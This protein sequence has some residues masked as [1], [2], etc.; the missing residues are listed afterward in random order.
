M[1]NKSFESILKCVT[2]EIHSFYDC[3]KSNEPIDELIKTIA[4]ENEILVDSHDF[5]MLSGISKIALDNL[6]DKEKIN[7]EAKQY[8]EKEKLKRE[9]IG[10]DIADSEILK[11]INVRMC[12]LTA[13]ALS[14]LKSHLL[15]ILNLKIIVLNR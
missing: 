6:G 4:D 1:T 5:K 10:Q 15:F 7:T 8:F 14:N 3:K 2:Q 13:V 9:K 12:L 11:E